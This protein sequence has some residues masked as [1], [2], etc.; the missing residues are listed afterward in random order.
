MGD[1]KTPFFRN[2][3]FGPV[4]KGVTSAAIDV[5]IG[6][7][8]AKYVRVTP[9]QNPDGGDTHGFGVNETTPLIDI[10]SATPVA[11]EQTGGNPA[12][13]YAIFFVHVKSGK[14]GTTFDVLATL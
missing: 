2:P 13:P 10:P 8:P 7:Q 9:N 3:T 14:A 11:Y 4:A 5:R 6:G 12:G 1:A